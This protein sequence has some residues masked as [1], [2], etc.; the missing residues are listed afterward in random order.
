MK[1]A[2]SYL[3]F[4]VAISISVLAGCRA[5]LPAE[6]DGLVQRPHP[7]LAGVW[8]KPDA[9]IVAY[10]NVMLDPVQISFARNWDP[11]SGGRTGLSRL[12]ASDVAAIKDTLA[13]LFRETFRAELQNGGYALVEEPGPDTLRVIPQIMD[14]YIT[15]PDMNQPARTR[16]YTANSG[17]MILVL[18]ARDSITG[19]ILARAVDG[20]SGGSAGMLTWTNRVTNIADARRAIT[21]WARALRE[22]LDDLYERAAAAAATTPSS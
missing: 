9:E 7:R 10:R 21:I 20:R 5:P 8:V 22:A 1:G 18:E 11:N 16:T 19:E 4:I 13:D 14:L 15:A 3:L 17:R 2:R 6:W 12:N